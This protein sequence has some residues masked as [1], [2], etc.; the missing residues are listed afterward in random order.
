MSKATR[1]AQSVLEKYWD[2]KLPINLEKIIENIQK[3]MNKSDINFSYESLD[4]GI[5]GSINYDKTNECFHIKVNNNKHIHHQRFTLAH[6]LGHYALSHGEKYD[7]EKTLF[8]NGHSDPDEVEANAFA[9]EILMP[10][11]VVNMLIFEEG[12][13]E[14]Q[15]LANIFKVSELAMRY[16]LK[17]LG[18]L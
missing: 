8:R 7:N 18:I 5:S 4:E 16:R 11:V 6:E 10:K 14:V 13:V 3:S 12:I 15:S 2:R 1:Y 17:N 9:A